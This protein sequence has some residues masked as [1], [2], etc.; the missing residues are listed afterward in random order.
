MTPGEEILFIIS[1]AVKSLNGH[2]ML[3][4]ACSRDYWIQAMKIYGTTRMTV[5]IDLA[6]RVTTWAEFQQIMDFLKTE[7]QLRQDTKV[8][9]RLWL[10][11]EI[12]ADLIPFGG[13]E[14]ANGE[15]AW[16][17]DFDVTLNVKGYQLAYEDA[18]EVN[19]GRTV[20]KVIRPCWLAMLKLKAFTD[21][22][23]R[24]K[25]LID[26]FFVIDHYL[27]FIDEEHRLYGPD[28]TDADI[29]SCEPFDTRIAG[30]ILIVRDCHVHGGDLLRSIQ[31]DILKFN[32]NDYLTIVF[33]RVNCLE[34][35]E[36]QSLLNTLLGLLA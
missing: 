20:L 30:A 16:P 31:T 26:V 2:L 1:E 35:E 29:F 28:A 10:R 18:V 7:N 9:H 25:D 19:I 4:G 24:T 23:G 32:S 36:A 21:N 6:C 11:D 34:Q 3:V 33:A 8:K 17:P 13:I 12:Y 27:E 15:Y 22:P 5:D 14:D